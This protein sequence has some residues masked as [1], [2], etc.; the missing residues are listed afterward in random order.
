MGLIDSYENWIQ[1]M[2]QS[3]K[4]LL[5][6]NACFPEFHGP[7]IDFDRSFGNFNLL[8]AEI[9]RLTYLNERYQYFCKNGETRNHYQLA[10]ILPIATMTDAK[11]TKGMGP[12]TRDILNYKFASKYY[13]K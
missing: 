11:S 4:N 2:P 12:K 1:K 10:E 13:E 6:Q 5:K 9:Q 3:A 8:K 7:G